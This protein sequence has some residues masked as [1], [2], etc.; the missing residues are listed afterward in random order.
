[1]SKEG[2]SNS[3]FAPVLTDAQYAE[4][5]T[6][7]RKSTNQRELMLAWFTRQL[8]EL[9]LTSSELSV[10]SVGCGNGDFDLEI[11]PSLQST[12]K[13]V[14]YAAVDP[15]Q[16]MLNGFKER[17]DTS[18][19]P[20]FHTTCFNCRFEEMQLSQSDR[21]DL[22]HFTHCLYFVDDRIGAIKRALSHLKDDGVVLI[23]NSMVAGIQDIRLRYSKPALGKQFA[24]FTGEEL[25]DLLRSE[26][27]E[28]EFEVLPGRTEITEC[29]I[30][31]S[32][33]GELLLDFFLDCKTSFLPDEL[34]SDVLRHMR[35]ISYKYGN[36]VQ[37]PHDIAAVKISA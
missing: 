20:R 25:R 8:S 15:N 7:F 21:F 18:A 17:I 30:P 5:F 10:L 26:H 16:V 2:K 24:T 33:T 4:S 12:G 36:R 37:M 34:R 29:F 35:K 19:P 6:A 22:I 32:G 11:V 9:R 3:A 13:E 27:I 23:L 28:H 31:G 14:H 1:M